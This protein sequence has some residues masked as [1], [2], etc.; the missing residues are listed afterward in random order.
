MLVSLLSSERPLD[1]VLC[2][3]LEH[4][5][6]KHLNRFVAGVRVTVP[7]SFIARGRTNLLLAKA[8]S[9]SRNN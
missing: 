7:S 5:L 2:A 6:C 8:H 1:E 4:S 9:A 3:S